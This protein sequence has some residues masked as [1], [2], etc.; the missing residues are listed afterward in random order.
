VPQDRDDE[1]ASALLARIRAE[2]EG[3]AAAGKRERKS[4]RRR[5]RGQDAESGEWLRL[6]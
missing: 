2:R 3:R 6:L 1:P 4:G 5:K